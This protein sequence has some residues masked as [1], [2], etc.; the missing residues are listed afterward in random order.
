MINNLKMFLF[1]TISLVVSLFSAELWYF[2][3]S[4]IIYNTFSSEG[5]IIPMKKSCSNYQDIR[6][7][8]YHSKAL[9]FISNILKI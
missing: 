4:Y 7:S 6:S 5:L 3:F 9:S 2:I 1:L 8:Y